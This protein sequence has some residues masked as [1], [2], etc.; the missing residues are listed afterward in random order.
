MILEQIGRFF[1]FVLVTREMKIFLF[2][3]SS[4]ALCLRSGISEK[5]N[6]IL[7]L[8]SKEKGN[9]LLLVSRKISDLK[10]NRLRSVMER[11]TSFLVLESRNSYFSAKCLG[12]F[13]SLLRYGGNENFLIW[14][15]H[16]FRFSRKFP[17]PTCWMC[18]HNFSDFVAKLRKFFTSRFMFNFSP[19][20]VP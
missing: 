18:L 9:L 1:L 10:L 4:F 8:S 5:G 6:V 12:G 19:F 17:K 15:F 11:E 20:H 2:I 3:I 16:V 14:T 7:S 13:P